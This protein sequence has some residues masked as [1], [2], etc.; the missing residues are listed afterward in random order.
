M[1]IS[2][3]KLFGH[4]LLGLSNNFF[5]SDFHQC[6]GFLH[7]HYS[8]IRKGLDGRNIIADALVEIRL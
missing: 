6:I 4:L 7:R 5:L 3:E 8:K 2:S 1:N